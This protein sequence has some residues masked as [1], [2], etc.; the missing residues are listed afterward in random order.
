MKHTI[1]FIIALLLC[2][3][4]FVTLLID[5]LPDL[6]RPTHVVTI[7]EIENGRRPTDSGA[8]YWRVTG[9]VWLV[10]HAQ[11]IKSK[12]S[13]ASYREGT[14]VYTAY[15]PYASSPDLPLSQVRVEGRALLGADPTI[16]PTKLEDPTGAVYFATSAHPS[17]GPN[18]ADL[19]PQAMAVYDFN[20]GKLPDVWLLAIPV[21]A[22]AVVAY[23]MVRDM[24]RRQ[25]ISPPESC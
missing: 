19:H 9:G 11:V 7:Q 20:D 4:C 23:A 21:L 18:R 6:R 3:G 25:R 12:A 14:D 10:D 17:A 8:E 5:M 16:D 22:G 24:K 2:S 15:I 1:G 13:I